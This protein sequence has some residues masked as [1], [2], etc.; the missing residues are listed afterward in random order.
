MIHFSSK[1]LTSTRSGQLPGYETQLINSFSFPKFIIPALLPLFPE[2]P[3]PQSQSSKYLNNNTSVYTLP[4]NINWWFSS[5]NCLRL[6]EVSSKAIHLIDSGRRISAHCLFYITTHAAAPKVHAA[7]LYPERRK[8]E[9]GCCVVVSLCQ[10]VKINGNQLKARLLKFA[11]HLN[12][13][14]M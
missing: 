10:N 11:N 4:A 5:A 13:F 12:P 2:A 14:I 9:A 8:E 3:G 1:H 6:V 7:Q